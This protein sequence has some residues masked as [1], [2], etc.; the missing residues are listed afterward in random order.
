MRKLLLTFLLL[1]FG[2][3]LSTSFVFAEETVSLDL[4][5]HAANFYSWSLGI[6]VM[7]ALGVLVFAG[8]LYVTS[9]GNP[10]RMGEAKKWI[11]AAVAGLD[12][13]STRPNSS[14]SSIS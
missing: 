7:L 13:K 2:I 6:G 11:T 14:H 9:S 5:E 12:R 8:F 10:S 4:A 1:F 3:F